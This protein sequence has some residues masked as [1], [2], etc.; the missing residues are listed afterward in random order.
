M[1]TVALGD[2]QDAALHEGVQ[3]IVFR[4]EPDGSGFDLGFEPEA[5]FIY[6]FDIA[7]DVFFQELPI[8][9][10]YYEPYSTL[11][12]LTSSVTIHVHWPG[13]SEKLYLTGKSPIGLD[14]LF[15]KRRWIP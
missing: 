4:G 12:R 9:E 8:R 5:E 13:V 10:V 7:Q 11:V 1:K 3:S 15:R 2:F 6:D 14:P